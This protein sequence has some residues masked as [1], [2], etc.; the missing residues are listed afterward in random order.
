VDYLLVLSRAL[1]LTA[2]IMMTGVVFFRA[3]I[4]D[5]IGA[6]SAQV[7]QHRGERRCD[8][9]LRLIFWIGLVLTLVSGAAWFLAVSAAIDDGPLS[10][11]LADGT[12]ATVLTETQFGQAWIVRIVVGTLLAAVVGTAKMQGIWRR[13]FELSLAAVFAGSLAFA[14]HAASTPGLKGNIHLASDVLHLIAVCAWV[15]SLVPYALYLGAIGEGSRASTSAIRE[16]TRRFSNLGIAAVLTIATTGVV[17]SFNLVG[18]AELLAHTEYG[19]LLSIKVTLFIAMIG[20]AAMNR[21]WLAP[22]LS[23]GDTT[24]QLRRNSLIETCFGIVI[25]CIVALL[26]TMPPALL[27]H[28][29]MQH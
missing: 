24:K 5:P 6:P 18:S 27:E 3:S 9:Q 11:P 14:G 23:D 19:R 29:G 15:G 21:F 25:V 28:A 16:A 4:A 8:R 26:G 10:Q 2:T 1:H 22:G 7:V 12:A 20:V 13:S 17:N